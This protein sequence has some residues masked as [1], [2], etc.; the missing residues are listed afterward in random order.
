MDLSHLARHPGLKGKTVFISGGGSG[1]GAAIVEAFVDQGSRVA[2]VDIDE[3]A[4]NDLVAAMKAQYGVA[5]LFIRCDITDIA[6]LQ[7]SVERAGKELGDIAVLVNNAASDTRHKWQDVTP[8]YWDERVAVNLRHQFFTI[9]SVVPQMQRLGGGSIINFGSISWKIGQGGMPAYSASKAAVHGLTR[10]TAR[11]LGVYKI[12][13]NTVLPGWVLTERQKKL[14]LTPEADK[15]RERAQCLKDG[16][17]PMDLARMV[18]FL[19]SDDARMCTSQE[20][21]VDGGWI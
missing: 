1:I 19:A 3:K 6:A 8:E 16:V 21:T 15:D 17:M 11:D 2:F 10:S 20:F 12:R 5:P 4:S 18:L 14:W 9:Q 13:V 7:A